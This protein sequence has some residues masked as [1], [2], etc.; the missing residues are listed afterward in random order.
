MP[1]RSLLWTVF[2]IFAYSNLASAG[3]VIDQVMKGEEESG[4]QQVVLQANQ[5]KTLMLGSEGNPNWLS[6]WASTPRRSPK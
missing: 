3:W 1:F 6:S 5:M 4:K 2:S